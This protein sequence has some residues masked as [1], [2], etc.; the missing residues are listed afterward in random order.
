MQSLIGQVAWYR[1]G[2]RD[3]GFLG[4]R[5][6][7]GAALAVSALVACG[8]IN[9]D[10]GTNDA[11]GTTVDSEPI[12]CGNVTCAGT[13]MFS[14]CNGRCLAYCAESVKHA[15]AVSRCQAWGGTALV[16]RDA[17]DLQCTLAL[18]PAVMVWLGYEQSPAATQP[19]QGWSWAGGSWPAPTWDGPEPNDIDG[20][21][22]GEENCAEL[23]SNGRANDS[24]C[25]LGNE[26]M[27]SR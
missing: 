16:I 15:E 19:D 5:L 23:Y 17:P 1:G 7:V 11:G 4:G 27:C 18:Q 8:R 26:I 22:S 3:A 14:M 9:F 24:V 13:A 21:E 6:R 2:I 12:A 20:V 25:T 10:A